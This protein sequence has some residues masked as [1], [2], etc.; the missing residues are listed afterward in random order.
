MEP[1]KR[2]EYKSLA[3]GAGKYAVSVIRATP[4]KWRDTDAELAGWCA[5]WAWHW[6]R[7]C[8]GE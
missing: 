6:A 3:E 5:R 4:K 2:P 1:F 7:R 8:L